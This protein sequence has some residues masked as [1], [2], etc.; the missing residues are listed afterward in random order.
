[1][2]AARPTVPSKPKP[3][4]SADQMDYASFL[5]TAASPVPIP[6]TPSSLLPYV[7]PSAAERFDDS[8]PYKADMMLRM[9]QL[10]RG[11]R[12]LPP[13]DRCRRLHMDCL[14][15]L[16]ACM[17]CTRK[18]AKCSW[19]EVEEQELRDHPFI[20]RVI[21]Q[22]GEKGSGD[23]ERT[24]GTEKE[25]KDWSKDDVQGVRDEELLG[26]E[27]DEDEG[28]VE[29]SAHAGESESRREV[30][31]HSPAINTTINGQPT[32]GINSAQAAAPQPSSSSQRHSPALPP[33]SL[34]SPNTS[35]FPTV[36]A[37][38][39]DIPLYR[40]PSSLHKTDSPS[41]PKAVRAFTA[42]EWDHHHAR[43]SPSANTTRAT[44]SSDIHDELKLAALEAEKNLDRTSSGE[45]ME[46]ERVATRVYTAGS[47][48]ILSPSSAAKPISV[49]STSDGHRTPP[50]PSANI[51]STDGNGGDFRFPSVAA[52]E[53]AAGQPTPPPETAPA[54]ESKDSAGFGNGASRRFYE[55]YSQ[56][57]NKIPPLSE[58]VV[59]D[60]SDGSSEERSRDKSL[61]PSRQEPTEKPEETREPKIE[62]H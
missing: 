20:P 50:N 61:T 37:R 44:P 25:K 42:H 34:S 55:N 47:E 28:R 17:G 48:P 7:K 46:R 12:V 5:H 10:N 62:G 57:N 31:S 41:S 4:P 33:P 16:T 32:R 53:A 9:E 2:A 29:D 21:L 59:L 26:E 40:P 30:K 24:K 35:A 38:K 14:K 27:S 56:L 18:H 11:D 58:P 39:L 49:T 15:N 6:N 22:A 23:E 51:A 13:C 52:T 54:V 3:K 43:H 45:M 8:G 1:M 36:N 19:K 60:L